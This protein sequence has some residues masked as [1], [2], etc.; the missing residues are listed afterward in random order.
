M[1]E[2]ESEDFVEFHLLFAP[3][4]SKQNDGGITST[5]FQ[6]SKYREEKK[7]LKDFL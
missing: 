5:T 1:F 3:S 2:I 4:C 6:R 7:A